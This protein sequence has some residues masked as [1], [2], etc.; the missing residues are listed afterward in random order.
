MIS[1]FL[2]H[3]GCLC[4]CLR[5]SVLHLMGPVLHLL[6]QYTQAGSARSIPAFAVAA[7][8]MVALAGF[9][10]RNCVV[11]CRTCPGHPAYMWFSGGLGPLVPLPLRRQIFGYSLYAHPGHQARWQHV[12]SCFVWPYL[13]SQ[14]MA[15]TH[16]CL[17]CQ[18]SEVSCYIFSC[19][20]RSTGSPAF[21]P[22]WF[23]PHAYVWWVHLPAD[24][25]GLSASLPPPSLWLGG[26]LWGVL[27]WGSS[28]SRSL[29]TIGA[30][31]TRKLTS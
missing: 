29:P 10:T 20:W 13:A 9:H 24:H 27:C 31:S 17:D 1:L 22:I 2:L 14:V 3:L 23:S 7:S 11:K 26:L 5:D 30:S 6:F 8:A 4:L 16:D 28:M 25:G 18:S 21:M 15:W 19:S 12:F